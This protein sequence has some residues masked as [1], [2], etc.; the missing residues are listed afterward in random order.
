MR[1]VQNPALYS[2]HA[3]VICHAENGPHLED[4]NKFFS[5]TENLSAF[6]GPTYAHKRGEL[7]GD[8]QNHDELE[9]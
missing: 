5:C 3:L 4:R 1:Q 6:D 9:K 8:R 2:I 7:R